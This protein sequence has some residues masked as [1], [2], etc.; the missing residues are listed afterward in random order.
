VSDVNVKITKDGVTAE[1]KARLVAEIADTLGR[2]FGLAVQGG[3]L[4]RGFATALLPTRANLASRMGMMKQFVSA[5]KSFTR[6]TST[7]TERH[8]DAH[9]GPPL[10]PGRF[11]LRLSLPRSRVTYRGSSRR[12]TPS[13]MG[14]SGACSNGRTVSRF[15]LKQVTGTLS[16]TAVRRARLTFPRSLRSWS[17]TGA[18]CSKGRAEDSVAVP[19]GGGC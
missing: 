15:T 14:S 2:V 16:S 8:P 17:L 11:V 7:S 10:S 13:G 12:S 9:D 3:W 4:T 5:I 19:D 6:A 1:Q 18:Y